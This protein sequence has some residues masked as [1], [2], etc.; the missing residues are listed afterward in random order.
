MR[1]NENRDVEEHP[2]RDVD[3]GIRALHRPHLP[4]GTSPI[5][6]A[7][8]NHRSSPIGDPTIDGCL[9]RRAG[10]HHLYARSAGLL[11][12]RIIERADHGNLGR[13]ARQPGL[14]RFPG[15]K[16]LGDI[17][18]HMTAQPLDEALETTLTDLGPATGLRLGTP[19]EGAA[20]FVDMTGTSDPSVVRC[21]PGPEPANRRGHRSM[22]RCGALGAMHQLGGLYRR[23]ERGPPAMTPSSGGHAPSDGVHDGPPHSM[24]DLHTHGVSFRIGPNSYG[25]TAF[26]GTV[27]A[28]SIPTRTS[29]SRCCTTACSRRRA[30][31]FFGR[32]P[33]SVGS[34]TW[35]CPPR[36]SE[37]QPPTCTRSAS[38]P[39]SVS[40]TCIPRCR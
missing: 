8:R 40:S 32:A 3:D 11:G 37:R 10:R 38:P 7:S 36:R 20:A 17:V 12:Q 15:G 26:G 9:T 19:D 18:E 31:G 1:A 29:R 21:R 33:E 27:T 22:G 39:A 25:H 14:R 13:P 28:S 4:I 16:L 5:I 6:S 23:L 2:Y 24:M 34:T 30:A 35:L